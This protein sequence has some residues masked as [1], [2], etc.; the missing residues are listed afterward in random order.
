MAQPLISR[1]ALLS[2]L[3]GC[4]AATA[5][6]HFLGPSR[7]LPEAQAAPNRR[8]SGPMLAPDGEPWNVVLLVSD[9]HSPHLGVPGR[10]SW[11]Q[12]PHLDRLARQGLRLD[13][14]Y[15]TSPVCAPARMGLFSGRYPQ[16]TGVLLNNHI[17]DARNPTFAKAFHDAGYQT[18]AIGKSHVNNS[19]STYGFDVWL[20]KETDTFR[21]LEQER[22]RRAQALPVPAAEAALWAGIQDRR[23]RGAPIDA[24]WTPISGAVLDLVERTLSSP[25][26]QPF[27]L[28]ASW[29]EPHWVW[30]LPREIYGMYDPASVALPPR[31]PATLSMVPEQLRTQNGWDRMTEAQHR[32]C[33]SRYAAAITYTDRVVGKILDLLEKAGLH[34]RTL[35]V[36]TSDH[37]DMAA[38]RRMWLKGLMYDAAA[39]TPMLMRMPGVLEG[40]KSSEVL[41]S[42]AD[43]FPTLAGLTGVPV[44]PEV[45]G[46]DL[47]G[48]LRGLEKGPEHLFCSLGGRP[49][50]LLPAQ[51]MVRDARHKLIRYHGTP[52]TGRH[53]IRELYD[54]QGDPWETE[55]ISG[56]LEGA[57]RALALAS[58]GDAW[59]ATLEPCAYG[60]QT[61]QG[62]AS[63][64]PNEDLPD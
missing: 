28:Y 51:L 49:N 19:G 24:E 16:E 15:A 2:A 10:P 55:D 12:T 7:G 29:T 20:T 27:F 57:E 4:V 9:E 39:G 6:A 1:R 60:L 30:D 45:S 23:L 59:L 56:S 41:F 37:G 11:V 54:M 35:L 26:T 61:L 63:Q 33:L 21:A 34:E 36:Y 13:H 25:P 52:E 40:G 50:N 17:F 5:G 38:E 31:G 48:A 58:A 47:S 3:G 32:L 43:L 44:P 53:E 46:K 62:R 22:R 64:D 8:P 18:I 14:S 42:G